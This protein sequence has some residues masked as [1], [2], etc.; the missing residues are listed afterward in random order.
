MKTV[1]IG[2]QGVDWTDNPRPLTKDETAQIH[3]AG[4]GLEGIKLHRQFTNS[5]LRA[6]LHAVKAL[7]GRGA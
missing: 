6:A 4:Y 1:I 3:A 7:Q 2:D 5:T